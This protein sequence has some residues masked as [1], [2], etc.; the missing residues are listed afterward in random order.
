MRTPLIAILIVFCTARSPAGGRA[1][2]LAFGGSF[3][4]SSKLFYNPN[5]SDQVL[6]GQFLGIDNIFG[7][8][9]EFRYELPELHSALGISAEYLTRSQDIEIPAATFTLTA[10][11]GFWAIPV[12]GTGFFY[13]PLGGDAFHFYMGGG[14]GIYFGTRRYEFPGVP[15]E[16]VDRTT[17]FGIHVLSGF[18]YD[19]DAR[20]SVRSE[21]KFRNV[22]FDALNQFRQPWI[23]VNNTVIALDTQPFA[24]RI[25]IVGM[26][27]S[28]ALVIHP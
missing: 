27:I 2:S 18:E 15:A 9:I 6:R 24:S 11:D 21:V 23:T 26:A 12:E 5:A 17:G 14:V 22:Q 16:T 1:Y 13:I 19:V 25:A 8:G 20:F 10:T 28:I 3:T 7:G 4:T